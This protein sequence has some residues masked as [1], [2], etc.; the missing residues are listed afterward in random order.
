[1]SEWDYKIVTVN[2]LHEPDL[3]EWISGSKG[4]HAALEKTLNSMGANG[5]ELVAFFPAC[6]VDQRVKHP[7]TEHESTIPANPWLYH[8]IFKKPSET[9]EERKSRI[10]DERLQRRIK[11]HSSK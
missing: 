5:W 8:A 11:E 1:M 4:G 9:W 7:A 3:L 2:T 10:D 6:P